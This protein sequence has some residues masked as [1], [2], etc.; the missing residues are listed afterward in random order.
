[1]VKLPTQTS[2][3]VAL[4]SALRVAGMTRAGLARQLNWH[5]EQVDR[6]F[7]LDH[8]TQLDQFDAAFDA[9]GKAL[10]VSPVVSARPGATPLTS[11]ISYAPLHAV[12]KTSAVRDGPAAKARMAKGGKISG[13]TTRKPALKK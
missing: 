4:W 6:L 9:L 10:V 2:I 13:E 5:R 12:A 8:A 11:D 1:M 7:R 3:K